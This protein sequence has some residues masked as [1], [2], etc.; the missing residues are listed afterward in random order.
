VKA[1]SGAWQCLRVTLCCLTLIMATITDAA[2]RSDVPLARFEY[3]GT[4]EAEA[5]SALERLLVKAHG[6]E[7][8]EL[9]ADVEDE[10]RQARRMRETALEVLA[11]EAYFSA[12]I[13]SAADASHAAHVLLRVTAGPRT[14]VR[15]VQC[16]LR[17]PIEQQPD[18]L[19]ELCRGWELTEGQPFRDSAWS[20]AKNHLLSHVQERDYAAARLVS[21]EATINADEAGAALQIVIDSGPAFRLGELQITGLKRYEPLLVRRYSTVKDGDR[22]DL[23]ELLEF[24][25]K[26]QQTPYFS[27]VVVAVDPDPA[28]AEAAPVRVE[29][30]EARTK[31]LSFGVGYT[32]NAGPRVESTYRQALLFGYPY[33]LQS[34]IGIDRTDDIVYAD[35]LLPPKP[36]DA[37]DSLGV[38]YEHTDIQNQ[39]TQRWGAGAARTL[40]RQEQTVAYE[41]KLQVNLERETRRTRDSGL[42]ATT[43]DVLSSRYTWTR[44][45]VNDVID[46]RSGDIVTLS[47][48]AGV[49]S[50]LLSSLGNNTFTN[51]Y[52]RYVRY[53]PLPFGA[54]QSNILILRGEA[55]RTFTGDPQ[56]VPDTFLYRTGGSG[57]VRGYGYQSLGQQEGSAVLGSTLLVVGSLEYVHWFSSEWGGAVFTDAG[58]AANDWNVLRFANSGGLGVRWKTIAGPLALDVARGEKRPDGNGGRWRLHFAVAIAF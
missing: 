14:R 18:R 17:G 19:A 52:G 37:L 53:Q 10:E 23:L 6:P 44:R 41:T 49:R 47:V 33:T 30:V 40:L 16:L 46:P 9:T 8:I 7:P 45:D 24:Q 28:Q 36:N 31:R 34:G 54:P 42:D 39:I 5:K 32:T 2:E 1:C 50:G 4:I 22:Y 26:L 35:I 51:L 58:D 48:G 21:S 27:S 43:N 57:S 13:D 3:I 56:F 38:L 25:R 11:T 12:R 29:L 15:S 55:G 20:A